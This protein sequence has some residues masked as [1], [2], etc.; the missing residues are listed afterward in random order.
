ADLEAHPIESPDSSE[1]LEDPLDPQNGIRHLEP[2]RQPCIT[3]SADGSIAPRPRPHGKMVREYPF[4]EY[5]VAKN[6][7]VS[8]LA[9]LIVIQPCPWSILVEPGLNFM[10]VQPGAFRLIPLATFS[11]LRTATAIASWAEPAS[12]GSQRRTP[13]TVPSLMKGA[14][15]LGRPTAVT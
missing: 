12:L 9:L 6:P 8:T 15:S 7:N 4:G 1:G 2:P 13:S 5:A 11:P 14:H 3:K 10:L